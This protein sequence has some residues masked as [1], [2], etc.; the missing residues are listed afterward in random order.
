MRQHEVDERDGKFCVCYGLHVD[1]ETDNEVRAARVVAKL[2]SECPAVTPDHARMCLGFASDSAHDDLGW[3][4]PLA[5][6]AIRWHSCADWE[7]E[8][9]LDVAASMIE[10]RLDL[11]RTACVAALGPGLG[12]EE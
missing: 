5:A 9:I 3:P 11:D 12:L 8:R 4:A 10:M 1:L 2:N 7:E 6:L